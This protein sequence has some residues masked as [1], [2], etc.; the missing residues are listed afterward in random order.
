MNFLPLPR[1][2]LFFFLNWTFCNTIFHIL[3]ED[4]YP[5]HYHSQY[6]D[7][8]DS[9]MYDEYIAGSKRDC[10]IPQF[11]LPFL[12]TS[13]WYPMMPPTLPYSTLGYSVALHHCKGMLWHLNQVARSWRL[14]ISV[15]LFQQ[16][17]CDLQ[18]R[19]E[20]CSWLGQVSKLAL[21][22]CSLVPSLFKWS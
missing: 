14:Q 16:Q 8:F 6:W 10:L 15:Q 21:L 7:P 11:A 1:V 9:T 22:D 5:S 3:W 20:L 4:F 12:K 2:F 18:F 19:E 13:L 17:P